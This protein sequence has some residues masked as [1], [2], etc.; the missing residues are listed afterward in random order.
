MT[1]RYSRQVLFPPIGQNGQ[2]VLRDKHVLII[3][4][5]ALG[6]ANAEMIVRA[7]VGHVTIVD[8]D[9]VDFSN[10][11][12]QN[13]YTEQDAIDR[14]PKAEAA[15]KRLAALNSDVVID[16]VTA[17]AD[18]EF[19]KNILS[20][21]AVDLIIDGTDNFDIR[22]VIND[23]AQ[24]YAIPW[25]YGACVASGGLSLFIIPGKTPCLHCLM[26]TIPQAGATCD[27]AGII[28]PAVQMTASAQTA[29]ALKW[30]TGNIDSLRGT[31][32]SFDLWTNHF[33][34]VD[35]AKLK[36]PDC[37]SCG[38]NPVYPFLSYELSTKFAVLCGRD[39][40]QIRPS[41]IKKRDLQLLSE[42][43]ENSADITHKNAFLISFKK[44]TYTI[45]A[46]Q[47]GRVFIHGTSSI[48]ESKKVYY[49]Y[50]Q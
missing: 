21:S 40:V 44:D 47:D 8:R 1:E 39:T 41:S 50:F 10:L 18:P 16:A 29:E 3:G 13:L 38:A 28:S 12:R 33:S 34:S 46:F 24:K 23:A 2:E 37:P 20:G 36:K 31:I 35:A 45:T 48:D 42:S 15:Q 32:F 30:L 43:V 4:A 27:T 19:F 7:G 11:Q 25:V 49:Q 9:Y 22:F 26:D 5:G 14:L 6:A 17:D